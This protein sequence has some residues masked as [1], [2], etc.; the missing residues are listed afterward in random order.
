MQLYKDEIDKEMI[1]NAE[2][3]R[4]NLKSLPKGGIK[5]RK[6]K[7][8]VS[9]Q[10]IDEF[11]QQFNKKSGDKAFLFPELKPNLIDLTDELKKL[12]QPLSEY[13]IYDINDELDEKLKIYK[14]LTETM[15]PQHNRIIGENK[16]EINVLYGKMENAT[17]PRDIKNLKYKQTKLENEI[18]KLEGFIIRDKGDVENLQSDINQLQLILN[19][20]DELIN[21]YKNLE[22]TVSEKNKKIL[23]DYSD[24]IR[25]LN[26]GKINI[27]QD[28]DETE[29]EY[30]IRL[31]DLAEQEYDDSELLE[32]AYLSN[33]NEFK[34]NMKSVLLSEWKIENI[35]NSLEKEEVFLLNK[36]FELFKRTALK[37]YGFNNKNISPEL[38]V[39]LIR[40]QFDGLETIQKSDP[41][42]KKKEP[43][44]SVY[45]DIFD[46]PIVES[47]YEDPIDASPYI[48]PKYSIESTEN[49]P[50]IYKLLDDGLILQIKNKDTE[51]FVNLSFEDRGDSSYSRVLYQIQDG[52]I[53]PFKKQPGGAT[54]ISKFEAIFKDYLGMTDEQINRDFKSKNIKFNEESLSRNLKAD[55]G[56]IDSQKLFTGRGLKEKL[57]SFIQFG[58]VIILLDKLY[59]KNT[60][61]IKDKN[62]KNIQG[63]PN[64]KVSDK[65]VDI[66]MRMIKDDKVAG[67]GDIYELDDKEQEL[68]TILMYKSGF[69]KETTT[70]NK[71]IIQK[72]KDRL[73]LVEG[74]IK[75]G[76]NNE[77]NFKELYQIIFK[78]TNLGVISLSNGRSYYKQI[79]KEYS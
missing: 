51:N 41:Y 10:M 53:L 17:K 77:D 22:F 78:M 24:N 70:N 64:K 12:K 11:K 28:P 42:Y 7:T 55:K 49:D 45:E 20:N 61:S 4:Q 56:L 44:D 9:Q 59:Y 25:I 39:E 43:E 36:T 57:P 65:F 62:K 50:I 6:I 3:Q 52:L 26:E 15:I 47:V 58:K 40:N 8:P 2:I 37:L 73:Q 18:K 1:L 38:Y 71:K 16:N 79:K 34:K 75:A 29:E 35:L 13:D 5:D 21:N 31:S 72:L 76:N 60:L 68:F 63:L 32:K 30:L 48:E 74:T 69:Y 54:F 19:E 27:S 46:E 66:I 67:T 14:L 33:I 23:S